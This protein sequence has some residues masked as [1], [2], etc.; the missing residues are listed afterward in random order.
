MP[1][2]PKGGSLPLREER[3]VD[4]RSPLSLHPKQGFR[5]PSGALSQ[6]EANAE[7]TMKP[8][9]AVLRL[10]SGPPRVCRLEDGRASKESQGGAGPDTCSGD[11]LSAF[12][13]DITSID[14]M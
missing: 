10:S 12:S 4:C 2:N 11:A 8:L 7:R 14:Y 13:L 6:K 5:D 9:K 1:R 3:L